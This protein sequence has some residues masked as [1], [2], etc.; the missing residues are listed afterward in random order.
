MPSKERTPNARA[1]IGWTTDWSQLLYV[2]R[3][4]T[5]CE[6]GLVEHRDSTRFI[7]LDF[8][9][10]IAVVAECRAWTGMTIA[11]SVKGMA[12]EGSVRDGGL[13]R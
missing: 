2:M 1:P 9:A 11:R 8:P 10:L 4:A 12:T 5:S 6:R 3:N 7:F 13:L